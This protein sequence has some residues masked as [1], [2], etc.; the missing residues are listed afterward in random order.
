MK[1]N[2]ILEKGAF[3]L[4]KSTSGSAG[5]DIASKEDV[6]IP[7]GKSAL[8]KTGIF[9]EL[10]S[11]YEAQIRSRSGLAFKKSIMVLNS[12]GTI[13]S[14]YRGEIGVLLMN[15]GS[16]D[17]DVKKGDRVAQVVFAKYESPSMVEV[18]SFDETKR[19]DGGWGSSGV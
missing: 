13:D 16:E 3:P 15:F 8:I 7:A 17:F 11:G 2:F 10:E 14:D 1:V 12:P 18:N 19:G 9:L 6:K 4:A 5:Y